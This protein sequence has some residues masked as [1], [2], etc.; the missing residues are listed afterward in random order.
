MNSN[1][2]FD[3]IDG[4]Q[5]LPLESS[6]YSF[7]LTDYSLLYADFILFPSSVSH[8][9]FPF[10][11]LQWHQKHNYLLASAADVFKYLRYAVLM[12]E[13]LENVEKSR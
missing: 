13:T 5:S 6:L 11:C 7:H 4:W 3:S 12:P 2:F 1:L 9:P 10:C 8:F